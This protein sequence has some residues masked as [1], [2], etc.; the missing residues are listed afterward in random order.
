MSG[1]PRLEYTGEGLV[2]ETLPS[3][4]FPLALDWLAAAQERALQVGDLIEPATILLGTV[5]ASG[6]PS[7]RPVL[8][9]IFDENGPGFYSH[10]GSRKA[11]DIAANPQVAASLVWPSLFR[12]IHFRG[13]AARASD[14]VVARYWDSRPRGAQISAVASHQSRP[15]V[16]R[17]ALE[18]LF[19]AAA[20]RYPETG[21]PIPV[22]PD[23]V[24]WQ[25]EAL[26]VEFWA[27]RA[28][29][30]H[31]RVLYARSGPGSLVDA[32]WTRTRLQP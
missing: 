7:V 9:R 32:V 14:D 27:G 29:R 24:G 20:A 3:S 31:D 18:D 16:D 11:N 4:P 12:C 6:M 15:V 19:A 17:A 21:T 30:L 8:M 23:F 22:P 1:T 10:L 25:I 2:E 28:D 26:E 5:S 13:V